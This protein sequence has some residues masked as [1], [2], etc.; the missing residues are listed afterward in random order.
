MFKYVNRYQ[1]KENTIFKNIKVKSE[2]GGALSKKRVVS[3]G[4]E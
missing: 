1:I 2:D 4:L 3:S